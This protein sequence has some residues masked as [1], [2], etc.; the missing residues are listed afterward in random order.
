MCLCVFVLFT[1]YVLAKVWRPKLWNGNLIRKLVDTTGD[2]A[3]EP[4]FTHCMKINT[5]MNTH[6]M[7]GTVQVCVE[8]PVASFPGLKRRRK[9]LISAI[10]IDKSMSVESKPSISDFVFHLDLRLNA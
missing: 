9:G 10:I 8:S 4:N 1:L 7:V 6:I 2:L 3:I 5:F